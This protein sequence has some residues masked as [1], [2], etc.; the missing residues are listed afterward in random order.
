M[1]SNVPLSWSTTVLVVDDT[2]DDLRL[3]ASI[4]EA[5]GYHVRSLANPSLVLRSVQAAPPDL[6]L[7]DVRMPDLDGYALC[8]ALKA[9]PATY[10]IPILFISALDD[11]EDKMKAFAA[12]GVDYITKPFQ[13]QEVLARVHTHLMLRQMQQQL[14]IQNARLEHKM[15][16]R[17]RIAEEQQESHRFIQHIAETLPL[18]LYVYDLLERR[19]VYR[20]RPFLPLPTI[21]EG[22][23]SI[24][25]DIADF[26]HPDDQSRLI[27]H[28]QTFATTSDSTVLEYQGRVRSEDGTWRWVQH[29][30]TIYTRMHDGQPRQILGAAI[31][32][33]EQKEIQQRL[34]Q[35]EQ[36]LA[37]LYERERLTRDL[38]DTLGQALSAIH[39]HIESLS[40]LMT[41]QDLD[42]VHQILSTLLDITQTAQNEVRDVIAGTRT[43]RELH[44]TD[45]DSCGLRLALEEHRLWLQQAYQFQM[46]LEIAEDCASTNLSPVTEFQLLHIIQEALTNVRKHAGVLTARVF[47]WMADQQ[48]YARIEDEGVGFANESTHHHE[49]KEANPAH[50]GLQSMRGRAEE[51][52][53]TVH[54]T[55]PPGNG[56]TVLAVLPLQPRVARPLLTARILLV[57]D[58]PNLLHS[59]RTMLEIR[60]AEVLGTAH[61]GHEAIEQARRLHPDLILM[62]IEMPR[63][64]GIDAT[65]QIHAEFPE[66]PIVMLTVFADDGLL[67][68]AMK[69]GAS[70]YLTKQQ[71]ADEMLHTLLALMRGEVTLAPD[72]A[73]RLLQEFATATT[74]SEETPPDAGVL[75]IRQRKV[76]TLVAR[77]YTYKEVGQQ[78]NYSEATIK[79]HMS[80]I[81]K[82]LH[83]KNRAAAIEY[84][85]RTLI[86]GG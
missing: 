5:Q 38:H 29:Y 7:L 58:N 42:P 21:P 73:H 27:A 2:I 9:D 32:I 26:V 15:A 45:V 8:H 49:T 62:D 44:A 43:S 20:N 85:Q 18:W 84:A 79:Y 14:H 48:I 66:M 10:D 59:L 47:L 46:E 28:I 76:L 60:G 6:I 78:L 82:K 75:S 13:A 68:D 50:Y 35:R 41:K 23:Q 22:N 71:T 33:T 54:I 19:P 39:M 1:S 16:E 65:R 81:I 3:L 40:R 52:G 57:D 30:H 64:N 36:A 77:G 83:L 70:G 80:T 37:M 53:G 74:H 61:N 4:L 69:Y 34:L 17:Q 12:G 56:T 25:A 86:R 51:I 24:E 55:S 72:L 31:D 11:I 63:L 67:F